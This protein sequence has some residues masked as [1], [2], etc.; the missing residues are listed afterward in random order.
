MKDDKTL[1]SPKVDAEKCIGCGACASICSE[2]FELSD[3]A[4]SHVIK[5]AD[6]AKNAKCIEEAKEACP[7]QAIS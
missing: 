2:V 1:N 3:D 7:V 6:I 5:D 4:K